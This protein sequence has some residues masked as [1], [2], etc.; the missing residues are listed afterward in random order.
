M[1]SM[2]IRTV[3]YEKM[4]EMFAPMADEDL[5]EWS[6]RYFPEF[7]SHSTHRRV[8]IR[9][10]IK[11]IHTLPCHVLQRLADTDSERRM[12]QMKLLLVEGLRDRGVV[13]AREAAALRVLPLPELKAVAVLMGVDMRCKGY[14]SRDCVV[15]KILTRN[16]SRGNRRRVLDLQDPAGDDTPRPKGPTL[17]RAAP[18]DS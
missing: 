13:Q 2:E 4:R 3:F 12:T 10:L 6:R 7:A 14:L 17:P 1:Q 11:P 5:R 8:L 18:R 16:Q 9:R 15:S